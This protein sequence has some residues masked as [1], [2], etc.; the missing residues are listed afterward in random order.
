MNYAASN[1]GNKYG[2]YVHSKGEIFV[3]IRRDNGVPGE[4]ARARGR[5]ARRPC[6]IKAVPRR[7]DLRIVECSG[8]PLPRNGK[9]NAF[10]GGF[11][12]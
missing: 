9:I 4:R 1:M 11:P 10:Q 2:S 8:G 6:A 5:G 3:Q 7:F 12:S